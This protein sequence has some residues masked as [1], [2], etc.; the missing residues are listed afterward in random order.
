[1]ALI[2]EPASSKRL[3]NQ[4]VTEFIMDTVEQVREEQKLLARTQQMY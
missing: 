3:G 4:P 1:V 2:R